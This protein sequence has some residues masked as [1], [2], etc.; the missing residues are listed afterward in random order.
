M[1]I[2]GVCYNKFLTLIILGVVVVITEMEKLL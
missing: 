2:K 1:P